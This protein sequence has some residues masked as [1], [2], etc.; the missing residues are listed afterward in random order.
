M[1]LLTL[2]HKKLQPSLSERVVVDGLGCHTTLH[3]GVKAKVNQ[4]KG[5][6]DVLVT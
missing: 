2:R 1:S 6:G 4:N 5:S 3:F